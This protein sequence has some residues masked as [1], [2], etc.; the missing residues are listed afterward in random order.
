MKSRLD[1]AIIADF[2]SDSVKERMLYE[3]S[4]SKKRIKAFERFSHDTEA[5]IRKEYIYYKGRVINDTIK[6]EIRLI[7]IFNVCWPMYAAMPAV[8][9]EAVENAYCQ[10]GWNLTT[11]INKYS[12]DLFPSFL[13]LLDSLR[14]VISRS[15]YSK[16]VK[17]LEFPSKNE[18]FELNKDEKEKLGIKELNYD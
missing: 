3:L 7:D 1:Y 5:I 18:S 15:D 6:S 9:K 17:D 13:D 11:S 2:L 4:S 10:C 12:Q 14:E 8:L 16:E